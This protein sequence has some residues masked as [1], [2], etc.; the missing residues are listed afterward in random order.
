M[1]DRR[2][3]SLA[4][5]NPMVCAAVALWVSFGRLTFVEPDPAASYVGILPPINLAHRPPRRGLHTWSGRST[6]SV[7]CRS[8]VAFVGPAST[9]TAIPIIAFVFIWTGL[10]AVWLWVA[11]AAA[12][13]VQALNHLRARREASRPPPEAPGED[14]A[15]ETAGRATPSSLL[16]HLSFGV[17]PYEESRCALAANRTTPRQPD[18]DCS[19]EGHAVP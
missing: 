15:A 10:L 2:R 1:V 17:L 7:R 18:A 14:R 13:L 3:P 19:D 5:V 6:T 4:S 11:I 9:V 12:L 16:C 8:T